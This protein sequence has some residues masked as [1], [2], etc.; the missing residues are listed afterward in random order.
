MRSKAIVGMLVVILLPLFSFGQNVFITG[1]AN[2]PNALVR[3][4]AYDEM[5][6]CHQTKLNET[7]ADKDGEFSLNATFDE[8]TAIQIAIDLERVDMIVPPGSKYNIEIVIPE[9]NDVSFF[10][11]EHPTLKINSADDNGFYAQYVAAEAIVS[12]FLYEKFDEIYRYRRLYL[13][14]TLDNQIERTVGEIKSEYTIDHIKYRKAAVVM[15]VS[16]KRAM[17]EYFDNQD[18]R[19][20]QMAYM[21]VFRELFKTEE[22]NG[23][24]LSAN[25]QLAELIAM[26]GQQKRYYANPSARQSVLNYLGNIEKTSKY[27]KNRLIA[28]NLTTQI[29]ELS[30]DSPA[31]EFSLKDKN[32]NDVKLSDYQDDIVLLQFVDR[33]SPLTDHEFA[34]LN[35]LHQNMEDTLKVVTIATKD[36]FDG[37]V[38]YFDKHDFKWQILNLGDDILLLENYHVLTFPN[39]VLLKRKGRVG[40]APA[41]SPDHHLDIHVRRISK[42]L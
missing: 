40:M 13:L 11:R 42:H 33:L 30:Y 32:G 8:T 5:F 34:T 21:D 4:L 1:K 16:T 23:D 31:P 12:D 28:A 18:V 20:S 6:T 2:R 25:P 9:Q 37:F 36:S 35:S 3:L 39:Y 10:E 17:V 27:K 15:A 22:K 19:Y 24:F 29:E 7:R 14:D 38:D 26:N 41:P